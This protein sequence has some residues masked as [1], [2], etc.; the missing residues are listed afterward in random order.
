MRKRLLIV[1]SA[2]SL[3]LVGCRAIEKKT[4]Q[5]NFL[6]KP[7]K[8]H[9][10]IRFWTEHVLSQKDFNDLTFEGSVSVDNIV[11]SYQRGLESQ[12]KC[13]GEQ[14][15]ILL[16]LVQERVGVKIP[17]K[18]IH[19][20]LIRTDIEPHSADVRLDVDANSITLPLWVVLSDESCE[21]IFSKQFSY[22]Y[23][24]VHEITECSLISPGHKS[25]VLP[26]LCGRWCGIRGC[27]KNY[28]RWFRD[29]LANYAGYVAYETVTSN[30][31]LIG[32]GLWMQTAYGMHAKPLSSLSKVRNSLFRWTDWQNQE[33]NRRHYSAALGLFLVIEKMFGENAIRQ[34]VGSIE[35][36][37]FVDGPALIKLCNKTLNTDIEKVVGTFWFPE[38]GLDLIPLTKARVL[39]EGYDVSEGLFVKDVEPGGVAEQAGIKK[40]DVIIQVNDKI[41]KNNLGFE[42]AILEVREQETTEITIWRKDKGKMIVELPLTIKN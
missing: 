30:E 29:G 14:F 28:T 32:E 16:R 2:M 8:G 38:M 17:F 15:S 11:V 34:I 5:E 7:G 10:H 41:V 26:D 12:A 20:C 3:V 23:M 40:K 22:P 13:V 42:L 6:R 4:V 35:T 31:E 1:L 25:P 21:S 37:E 33:L 9:M 36:V 27:I 18:S 24:L 39:N 19:L